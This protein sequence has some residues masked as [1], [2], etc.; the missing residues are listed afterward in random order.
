M[1]PQV[2]SQGEGCFSSELME[3]SRSACWCPEPLGRVG[4]GI[5]EDS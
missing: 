5:P 3:L 4:S 2:T 1:R